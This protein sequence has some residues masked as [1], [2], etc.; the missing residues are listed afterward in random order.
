MAQES[1]YFSV[2]S[3]IVYSPVI[4]RAYQDSISARTLCLHPRFLYST[5]YM[6]TSQRALFGARSAELANLTTRSRL[7]SATIREVAAINKETNFRLGHD[8]AVSEME[9]SYL[10]GESG[11][12]RIL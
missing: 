1:D 11:Q 6:Q 12:R 7:K 5:L 4:V 2:I 10:L 3:R 8:D 9:L